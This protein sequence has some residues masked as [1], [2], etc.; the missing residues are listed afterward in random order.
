[1]RKWNQFNSLT[2]RQRSMTSSWT[3]P[4]SKML[5]LKPPPSPHLR[6]EVVRLC[7]PPKPRF[8]RRKIICKPLVTNWPT[9]PKQRVR[10]WSPRRQKRA[11]NLLSRRKQ[12]AK[13]WP[14]K[15]KKLV[16]SWPLKRKKRS[17]NWPRRQKRRVK[18]CKLRR[19]NFK[20][21]VRNF[22]RLCPNRTFKPRA[23][24]FRR[25]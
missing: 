7:R 13:N 20:R 4:L 14:L 19:N 16:K 22:S 21:P 8:R 12:R 23:R 10:S 24:R 2:R 9:R 15:R 5:K 17:R 11:K 3:S 18:N 6:T 25:N 1:M